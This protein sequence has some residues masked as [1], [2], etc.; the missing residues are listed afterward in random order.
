MA[1]GPP[2]V[3]MGAS[4]PPITPSLTLRYQRKVSTRVLK[5]SCPV[6]TVKLLMR[7]SR[8]HGALG[9]SPLG[10][11]RWG[12]QLFQPHDNLFFFFFYMALHARNI[13]HIKD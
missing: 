8:W 10:A 3:G 2:T 6:R 9:P 11:G 7:E 5:D 1:A 13:E 4:Q 12:S